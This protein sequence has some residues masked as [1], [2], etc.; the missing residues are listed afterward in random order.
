MYRLHDSQQRAR[1]AWRE[2]PAL[3]RVDIRA[4]R[5]CRSEYPSASS[6]K[7]TAR[8]SLCGMTSSSGGLYLGSSMP[9]SGL[10]LMPVT[11]SHAAPKSMILI[12][13]S[14]STRTRYT[15]SVTVPHGNQLVAA[16]HTGSD[17]LCS[18]HT[19]CDCGAGQKLSDPLVTLEKSCLLTVPA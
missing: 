8:Y 16:I 4:K 17:T 6:T 12:C 10:K 7:I 2:T 14:S 9:Y 3:R 11:R 13:S 15:C 19:E 18:C 5:G 1:V